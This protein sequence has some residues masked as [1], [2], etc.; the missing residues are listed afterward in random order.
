[1]GPITPAAPMTSVAPVIVESTAA[2]MTAK[3]PVAIMTPTV[4]ALHMAIVG[5]DTPAAPV[6]THSKSRTHGKSDT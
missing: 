2:L 3:T 6:T 1:M 5:A 4:R